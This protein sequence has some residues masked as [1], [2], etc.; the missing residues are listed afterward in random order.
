MAGSKIC[1]A[2]GFYIRL[3]GRCRSRDITALMYR[4]VEICLYVNSSRE[5]AVERIVGT[6]LCEGFTGVEFADLLLFCS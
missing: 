3:T 6:L 5:R 4:P 1:D 2:C